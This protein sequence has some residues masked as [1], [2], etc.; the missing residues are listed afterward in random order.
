MR[1]SVGVLVSVMLGEEKQACFPEKSAVLA[2]IS[3]VLVD[4]ALKPWHISEGFVPGSAGFLWWLPSIAQSGR[5]SNGKRNLV[6][7]DLG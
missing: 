1:S 3:A 6:M 5:H 7:E 2:E 4:F